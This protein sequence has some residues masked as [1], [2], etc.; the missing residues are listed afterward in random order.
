[1]PAAEV[2][3]MLALATALVPPFAFAATSI[4]IVQL[5][6]I[7]AS[8]V[9]SIVPA[10]V[11]LTSTELAPTPICQM[12][13]SAWALALAVAPFALALAVTLIDAPASLLIAAVIAVA[14]P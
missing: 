4:A 12:P 13:Q 10:L 9:M 11:R 5:L 7:D 14:P 3:P 2:P 6:E 8:A 1:M